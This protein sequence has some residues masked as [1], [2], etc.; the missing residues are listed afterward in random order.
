MSEALCKPIILPP[1]ARPAPCNSRNPLSDSLAAFAYVPVVSFGVSPEFIVNERVSRYNPSFHG[2]PLQEQGS[3]FIPPVKKPYQ[4]LP[5]DVL[6]LTVLIFPPEL[7]CMNTAFE[8]LTPWSLFPPRSAAQYLLQCPHGSTFLPFFPNGFLVRDRFSFKNPLGSQDCSSPIFSHR[9]PVE[10]KP[11]SCGG[12]IA[13][14]FLHVPETHNILGL[15]P[16]VP[17]LRNLPGQLISTPVN[18]TAFAPLP[19]V[20][21]Q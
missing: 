6:S 10:W 15:R 17:S 7:F 8:D 20:F 12:A 11:R 18:T 3:G 16:K 9:P 4:T 1:H 19:P 13:C 2:I 5:L 21:L 14:F